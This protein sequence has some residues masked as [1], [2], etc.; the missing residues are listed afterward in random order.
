[1][2]K[3]IYKFAIFSIQNG[4][5]KF[6]NSLKFQVRL[7]LALFKYKEKINQIGEL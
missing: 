1:M 2:L 4:I 3:S 7:A 5:A 6:G